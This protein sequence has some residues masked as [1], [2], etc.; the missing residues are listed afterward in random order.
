MRSETVATRAL[1]TVATI[2]ES[3]GFV[4]PGSLGEVLTGKVVASGLVQGP[5]NGGTGR[6]GNRQGQLPACSNAQVSHCF[7]DDAVPAAGSKVPWLAQL[8][9]APLLESIRVH[10][11]ILPLV[12]KHALGGR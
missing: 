5:C 6:D 12:A 2:G 7:G 10:L 3:G 11:A 1:L 4:P 9:A 8:S